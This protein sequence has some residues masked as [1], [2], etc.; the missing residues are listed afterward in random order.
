MGKSIEN[1]TQGVKL[2]T[3]RV[4]ITAVARGAKKTDGTSSV[5]SILK[6]RKKVTGNEVD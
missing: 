3:E 2:L 1:R 5:T 6:S 4:G